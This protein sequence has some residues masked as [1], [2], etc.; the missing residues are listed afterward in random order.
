[1][2]QNEQQQTANKAAYNGVIPNKPL[3]FLLHVSAPHKWW[4]IPALTLVAITAA[5]SQGSNYFF[6]LIIDAAEAGDTNMALIYGLMFPVAVLVVQLLFRTSGFLGAGW[7]TGVIKTTGDELSTYAFRHS[8]TYFTN[9]FAGSVLSKITNVTG[10]AGDILPEL[11]WTHLTAFVSFLVTFGFIMSVDMR[12]AL[13]F[14][15]LVVVLIVVNRALAPKKARLSR[16]NAEANTRLRG[17]IVD[18]LSNI[19]AVRQYAHRPF[20]EA[21][22]YDLTDARREAHRKN[23]MYTEKML[24]WNSIILFIFTF[25]MFWSLVTKWSAGVVSTGEFVLILALI[26]QLTGT[27]IFIGRA[28]NATARSFGEMEEGLDD[29]LVPYEIED[30]PNARELTVRA[31]TIT[32][33]DVSFGFGNNGVFERFA[34]TIEAGQRVG[35][36]GP[37]GAGKSTFVSLLLRQH[38]VMSGHIFIDGQ[39][40]STV[41][42][43][44]LRENIAVVPQ[45]PMLFHRSIR[46]NIAY[47]NLDATEEEIIAVAKKAEAH[48]FIVTLEEGY[49]TLVGERGVK[50]S[51]GQKQRVAIARAMLKDAPILMLDEATSALDSESEVAIQKALHELMAGKTVIAIAHRLSTLREMDRILVLKDGHIVEDGT[52]TEL[53]N[54]GQTYAKLWKHQAGGFLQE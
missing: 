4:A 37:S 54:A 12:S 3:R 31:G 15:A 24:L 49:E 27:L 20:E 44:S 53:V 46:V 32:W 35:L 52:H 36:V 10:A 38:D 1:M 47:G 23:W 34:L 11:M 21:G 14:A 8:H 29:I 19:A 16:A 25:G 13:I 2:Q 18:V 17:R 48:D 9:R 33:S 7:V 39:D 6:K 28:C 30:I 41:T 5:L 42:Q 50:L 51:G 45:E 43:D 26:S 40:I 22:V